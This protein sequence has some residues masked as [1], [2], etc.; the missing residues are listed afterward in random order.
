M[1]PVSNS[2]LSCLPEAVLLTSMLPVSFL[3][4]IKPGWNINTFS[5]R[6]WGACTC[7]Q[8]ISSYTCIAKCHEAASKSCNVVA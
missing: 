3:E 8:F 1:P 7:L 6:H 4:M 5:A 2:S